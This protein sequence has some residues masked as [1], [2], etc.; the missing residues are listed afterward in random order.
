MPKFMLEVPALIDL[1]T[2]AFKDKH[3]PNQHLVVE[4]EWLD[5]PPGLWVTTE[6]TPK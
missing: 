1:L 3:D 4:I 5:D 2:E 6:V